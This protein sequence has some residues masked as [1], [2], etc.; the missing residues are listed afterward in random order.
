[1]ADTFGPKINERAF[2]ARAESY[3]TY[4]GSLTL[5]APKSWG[6]L[7]GSTLTG[8]VINGFNSGAS[9]GAGADQT[10]WYVGGTLNTPLKGLKVGAAYDYAGVSSQPLS[11]SSYANAVAVY[12]SYQATE[13]LSLHAPR[14]ICLQRCRDCVRDAVIGGAPGLRGHRHLAIRSVEERI[15]PD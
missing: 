2:P 13:K 6:A 4:M 11:G 5:T 9:A 14:R 3:K 1:M 12:A 8:C 15:E 10:S 7:A